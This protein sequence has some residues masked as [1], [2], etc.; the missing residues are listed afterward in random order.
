MPDE[1]T[2]V[3]LRDLMTHTAT[4]IQ[5]ATS[6][7]EVQSALVPAFNALAARY[8]GRAKDYGELPRS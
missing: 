2:F 1:P 6:L 5:Q 7:E 3:E 4:A 8:H